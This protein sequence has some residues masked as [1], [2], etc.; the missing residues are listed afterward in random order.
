LDGLVNYRVS[1]GLPAT[2]INFGQWGEVGLVAGQN[3]RFLNPMTT[4]EGLNALGLAIKSNLTNLIPCDIDIKLLKQVFPWQEEFLETVITSNNIEKEK[5]TLLISE[6]A[7]W[8]SFQ[9]ADGIEGVYKVVTNFVARCVSSILN[10][11]DEI[12][13]NKNLQVKLK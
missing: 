7:F 1:L 12:D 5:D 2:T 11:D 13:L 8:S 10:S 4:N 3:I 6:D 9:E